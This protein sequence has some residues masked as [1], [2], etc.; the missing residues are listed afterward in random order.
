[1]KDTDTIL[2]FE[3][4]KKQTEHLRVIRNWAAFAGIML[5]IVPLVWT[6]IKVLG[7]IGILASMSDF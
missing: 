5:I 1:M 7:V 6:T 4:A 3:E 2:L